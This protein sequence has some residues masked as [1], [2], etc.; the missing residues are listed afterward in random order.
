MFF[1][2]KPTFIA[3]VRSSV[4]DMALME[5]GR[6]NKPDTSQRY[7]REQQLQRNV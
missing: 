4:S 3:I 6:V 1:L 2:L 5:V 7:D